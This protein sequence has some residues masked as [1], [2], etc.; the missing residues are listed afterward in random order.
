MIGV[1]ITIYD[2]LKCQETGMFLTTTQQD[3]DVSDE[4]K[5]YNMKASSSDNTPY[6]EFLITQIFNDPIIT[7]VKIIKLY[8]QILLKISDTLATN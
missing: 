1:K 6:S 2:I 7:N 5:V 8:L 4:V 3:W